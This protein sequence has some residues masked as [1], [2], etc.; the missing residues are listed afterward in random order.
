MIEVTALEIENVGQVVPIYEKYIDGGSFVREGLYESFAAPG[1]IGYQALADGE[2]VGF[3]TG[4][5]LLEFTVPHPELEKEILEITGGEELFV[6]SSMLVLPAY[7]HYGIAHRFCEQVR[8]DLKEKGV[9]YFLAEIWIFPDG[10]IPSQHVYE[11]IGEIVY[12]KRVDGFYT[13][14]YKYGVVCA[15]C[16]EHCKCGA[17]LTLMRI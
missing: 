5:S 1:F 7:R 2:M 9:R 11:E 16:G 10:S 6:V 14:G 4:S 8:Q 12:Q 17:L 3:F 15:V 13:E